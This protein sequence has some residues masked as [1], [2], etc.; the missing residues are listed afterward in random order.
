MRVDVGRDAERKAQ[1]DGGEKHLDA[2]E[3]VLPPSG[4]GAARND[5]AAIFVID[6]ID[7]RSGAE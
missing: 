4:D 7:D 3:K 2:R 6:G 5:L 1:R